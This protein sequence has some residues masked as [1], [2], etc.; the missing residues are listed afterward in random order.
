MHL[1]SSRWNQKIVNIIIIRW[2]RNCI[3]IN[4]L[5]SP[6][7]NFV[8]FDRRTNVKLPV[9]V[10][11]GYLRSV[12][13]ISFPN[14]LHIYTFHPGI[15]PSSSSFHGSFCSSYLHNAFIKFDE[16]PFKWLHWGCFVADLHTSF[17][18]TVF[19]KQYIF[20]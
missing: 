10:I 6:S 14:T 16:W 12:L 17:V 11:S 19:S 7:I 20:L 1:F 3:N 9:K 18:V 2:F 15:P 13:C 5:S 8:R 4:H